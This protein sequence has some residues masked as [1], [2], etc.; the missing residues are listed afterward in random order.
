MKILETHVLN[1]RLSAPG[2]SWNVMLKRLI[3][4]ILIPFDLLK[5]GIEKERLKE[6]KNEVNNGNTITFFELISKKYLHD[7]QDSDWVKTH[8][9]WKELNGLCN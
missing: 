3:S 6:I 5:K 8:T 1:K 2:L 9:K 7:L 4:L